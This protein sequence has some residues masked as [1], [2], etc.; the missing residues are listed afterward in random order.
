MSVPVVGVGVIGGW[1]RAWQG[2]ATHTQVPAAVAD[3]PPPIDR[4]DAFARRVVSRPA[5]FAAVAL[6]DAVAS[7]GW[8]A[9]LHDVGLWLGVG[10]SGGPLSQMAKLLRRSL[11]DAG[12]LDLQVLGRRGLRAVNPLFAFQL[13]NNFTLCHPAICHDLRGPN[14]AF[15]SRGSGTLVA[16]D[17]A[18]RAILAGECARAIAGGSDSALHPVTALEAAVERPSEGAALLALGAGTPLAWLDDCFYQRARPEPHPDDLDL[19]PFGEALAAS[20]AIGC[21]A[22][23][24]LL[25]RGVRDRVRVVTSGHDGQFGVAVLRAA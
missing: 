14:A 19:G 17:E 22:A 4:A 25:Q 5:V 12:A 20:P 11:D 9:P 8:S 16:L 21:A 6:A 1:G 13:M 2:L 7:A 15:F 18:R 3:L 23:V 24:D 10:A